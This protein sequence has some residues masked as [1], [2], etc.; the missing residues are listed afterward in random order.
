MC[1]G[2]RGVLGV[3]QVVGGASPGAL[4]RQLLGQPLGLP[5]SLSALGYWI[6]GQ[7]RGCGGSLIISQGKPLTC[8]ASTTFLLD[9]IV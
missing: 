8:S 6:D 3:L 4:L 9:E 5:G 1:A 7:D 2:D